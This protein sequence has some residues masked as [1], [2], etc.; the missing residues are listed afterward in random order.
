[1]REYNTVKGS[2]KVKEKKFLKTTFFTPPGWTINYIQLFKLDGQNQYYRVNQEL[3]DRVSHN[4]EAKK[5]IEYYNRVPKNRHQMFHRCAAVILYSFDTNSPNNYYINGGK[6]RVAQIQLHGAWVTI[7]RGDPNF[8][9]IEFFTKS[10]KYDTSLFVASSSCDKFQPS[11]D[12]QAMAQIYREFYYNFDWENDPRSSKTRWKED[13]SAWCL[14]Y[15]H[16]M[17]FSELSKHFG[18]NARST[19]AMRF[20]MY[21]QIM[22]DMM[23]NGDF[24]SEPELLL[25]IEEQNHQMLESILIVYNWKKYSNLTKK[26][27]FICFTLLKW[28]VPQIAREWEVEEYLIKAFL[29]EMFIEGK[30]LLKR[31]LIPVVDKYEAS[32]NELF[33]Y[34]PLMKRINRKYLKQDIEAV[35]KQIEQAGK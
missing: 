18:K 20:R 4:P 9:D 5:F 2:N 26:Q 17:P 10:G 28:T 7:L 11:E 15:L 34:T 8:K 30:K 32:R 35:I 21:H 13:K 33:P 6:T 1:M 3:I 27:W 12:G 24:D 14:K 22:I 23:K 31:N 25:T 29:D 16:G 19:F